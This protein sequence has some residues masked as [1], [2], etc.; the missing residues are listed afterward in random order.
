MSNQ[1]IWAQICWLLRVVQSTIKYT[2]VYYHVRYSFLA[3][4]VYM[5]LHAISKKGIQ[6]RYIPFDGMNFR[7]K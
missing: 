5:A 6:Y 2:I 1:Y 4:T 3:L 7:V